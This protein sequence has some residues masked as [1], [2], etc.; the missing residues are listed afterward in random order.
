MAVKKKSGGKRIK[1][2]GRSLVW[3]SPTEEQKERIRAAAGIAGKPMSQ[4]LL[5]C[6]LAEAVKIIAKFQK[7]SLT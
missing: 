7:E 1:E 6:G 4:F 2:Q 5:D 3:V